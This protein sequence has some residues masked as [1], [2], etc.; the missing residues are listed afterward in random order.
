[1]VPKDPFAL[2]F[3]LIDTDDEGVRNASGIV[4][5]NTLL[6]FVNKDE[7][8]RL[9]Q[10]DVHILNALYTLSTHDDELKEVFN[11]LYYSW[12]GE[13]GLTR[14]KDGIERYLQGSVSAAGTTTNPADI[15]GYGSGL[16][17]Y[18]PS[19][20][21]VDGKELGGMLGGILHRKKR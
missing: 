18:Q 20:G 13:L 7:L 19:M 15:Q 1:M 12:R 10:N 14:T 21:G 16:P 11:Q 6:S 17:Q 4:D 2:A 3:G 9:Y 5:K 8:L